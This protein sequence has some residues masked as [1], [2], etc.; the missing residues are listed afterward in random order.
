MGDKVVLLYRQVG[1]GRSSGIEV[2][3]RAGWV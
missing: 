2:E 1:R 3:E